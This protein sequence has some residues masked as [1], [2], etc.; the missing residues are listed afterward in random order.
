MVT[1]RLLYVS[2][3][4]NSY[5]PEFNYTLRNLAGT[6]EWM[7]VRALPVRF[8]L[9]SSLLDHFLLLLKL[10]VCPF[11]SRFVLCNPP[12]LL[13]IGGL[14]YCIGR[15]S[16]DLKIDFLET[17][18]EVLALGSV[19]ITR[20]LQRVGPIDIKRWMHSQALPSPQWYPRTLHREA[21][22]RFCTRFVHMLAA[23][24]AAARVSDLKLFPWYSSPLDK[25]LGPSPC[26]LFDFFRLIRNV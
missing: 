4:F 15:A 19:H 1:T 21:N 8:D 26:G 9:A 16:L 7:D 17:L 22:G 20:C 5:T 13:E 11:E 6:N 23:R 10:L 14:G 18:C 24:A 12:L 3:L 2:M 25:A